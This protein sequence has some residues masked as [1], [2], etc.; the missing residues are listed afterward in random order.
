MPVCS[1]ELMILSDELLE[2]SSGEAGI[3]AS[4]GR[5]YYALFHEA[6]ATAVRLSLPEQSSK[7]GSHEAL[8]SRFTGHGKRLDIIARR[9]R[10]CKILRVKADYEIRDEVTK[11]D[12]QV[13]LATCKS[14]SSELSRL[15]QTSNSTA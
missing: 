12:A 14:I 3:R 6:H 15:V 10:Q 8:I 2:K 9:I 5:S 7:N 13:H 11:K 1:N 4:I